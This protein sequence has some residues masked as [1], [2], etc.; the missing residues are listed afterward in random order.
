[1]LLPALG[2]PWEP[3]KLFRAARGPKAA[4]PA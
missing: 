4:T 3:G 1:V 2:A